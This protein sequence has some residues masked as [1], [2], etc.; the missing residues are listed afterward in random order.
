MKKFNL[1]FALL[2]IMVF[3]FSSCQAVGEVFKAGVWFG[4]IGIIVVVAIIFWL[5]NKAGKK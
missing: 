1:N 4:I 5:I 2:A 3:M